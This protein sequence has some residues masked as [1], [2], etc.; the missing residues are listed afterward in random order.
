MMFPE[1]MSPRLQKEMAEVGN[2]FL[3]DYFTLVRSPQQRAEVLESREPAVIL[4]TSGMMEGGPVLAYFKKLCGDER[5]LLL[6][7]SYQVEGT[8]GRKILKGMREVQIMNEEG[9]Y[10]PL[11]VRMQVEKIDGFS[12]HSSRQQLIAYMKRV[13]PKPRNLIFVHGEPEAISS[14]ASVARKVVPGASIYMPKNLDSVNL[15]GD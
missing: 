7:V 12:G 8:L 13:S 9:K 14:I 5:N 10:E 15:T 6:F 3:S 2:V 1:Y 4:A 11:T